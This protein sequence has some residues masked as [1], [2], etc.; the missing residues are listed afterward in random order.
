[1]NVTL[2]VEH[3]RYN[4]TNTN[5][6]GS[7]SKPRSCPMDIF[8]SYCWVWS[9]LSL[10]EVEALQVK[11]TVTN[12]SFVQFI[13]YSGKRLWPSPARC[14][15]TVADGMRMQQLAEKTWPIAL[16][17]AEKDVFTIVRLSYSMF[18]NT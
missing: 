6:P 3:P 9:V 18:K 16:R 4:Y 12:D 2:I 10:V 17:L 1:M 11:I 8:C 7:D 14:L 5:F 13:A 15:D